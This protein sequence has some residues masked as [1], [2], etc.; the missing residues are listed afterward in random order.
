MRLHFTAASLMLF[1]AV[2]A[3]QSPGLVEARN[4]IS[5]VAARHDKVAY[6]RF[7][8]DDITSIDS[9]GKLRDK[10]AA[11]ED[12]PTGRPQVDAEIA[13]YG[14]GAVVAI[15]YLRT[16]EAPAR[17]I[18]AWSRKGGRWQMVAFQGV[19]ATGN[20]TPS[21]QASSA[22]PA[23]SGAESD[24][25]AVQRTLD[26]LTRAADAGDAKA[27]GT[28]V[29]NRFVETS[30]T[31]KF[32]GKTDVMREM[33]SAQRPNDAPSVDQTSIRVHGGLGVATMHLR[34]RGSA[35]FWRT[36]VLVREN[37]RWRLAAQITT[38]ITGAA[39]TSIPSRP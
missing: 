14:D 32:R 19:R 10:A 35:E 12:M 24:R 36:A 31:G 4:E 30:S 5:A 9:A 13:D 39:R 23:S 17:I 6:A 37:G 34:G 2:A 8:S 16:G 18:Q 15:G 33:N 29:T 21:T 11:V 20:V 7:L 22:L 38:P 27:W 1:H 28:L 3:A 26:S 25:T